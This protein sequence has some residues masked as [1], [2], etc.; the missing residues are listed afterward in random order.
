ML[1]NVSKAILPATIALSLA[2]FCASASLYPA[3]L[4]TS[5]ASLYAEFAVP[6]QD[7]AAS[8]IVAVANPT[9]FPYSSAISLPAAL[10]PAFVRLAAPPLRRNSGNSSTI[11]LPMTSAANTA[12][13]SQAAPAIAF[14]VRHIRSIPDRGEPSLLVAITGL[15]FSSKTGLPS[16]SSSKLAFAT[17]SLIFST[18][19]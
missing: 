4:A 6:P 2:K 14:A 3:F 7:S 8:A 1:V 17:L 18:L 13:L 9:F 11:S 10:N 15:P 19:C 5:Y 16:S 12:L